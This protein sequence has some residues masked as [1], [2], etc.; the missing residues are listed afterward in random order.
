M[1][2]AFAKEVGEDLLLCVK[3]TPNA[4]KNE[5]LY[6][7]NSCHVRVTVCPEK[8]AANDVALRVIAKSLNLA[9]SRIAVN[10][11]AKTSHET[12]LIKAMNLSEC[13]L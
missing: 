11:G 1:M 2:A 13:Y 6:T 8:G 12:F 5:I 4:S 9:P 7:K 10:R 3:V